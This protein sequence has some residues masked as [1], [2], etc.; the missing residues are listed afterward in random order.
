M[1]SFKTRSNRKRHRRRGAAVVEFAVCLPVIIIIVFGAIEAASLLFLRQALI[2]SAY[3]GAKVAIKSDAQNNDVLAAAQSVAAGR[4][5]TDMTVALQPADVSSAAPGDLIRVT[6][7]APGD[8]NSL[9][10]YGP[11]KNRTISARAVMVKE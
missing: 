2:Q 3:E 9:I 5:L 7:S 6:I 1:K 8:S 10:Q 11:F 4:N